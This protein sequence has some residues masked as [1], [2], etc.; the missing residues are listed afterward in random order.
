MDITKKIVLRSLP[1]FLVAVLCAGFISCGDDDEE[2]VPPYY[3]VDPQESSPSSASQNQMLW[4]KWEGKGTNSEGKSCNM[5]LT[6]K[7]DATGHILVSTSGVIMLKKFNSY[8]Y[9]GSILTL[10]LETGDELILY[11]NSL[12]NTSMSVDFSDERGKLEA[13]YSLTKIE[14][15]SDEGGSGGSGEADIEEAPTLVIRHSDATGKYTTSTENYYKKLS[16]TGKYTLCR[17]SDGRGEIGIGSANNLST[18]GGYRVSS[19][20]Y[21]YRDISI[22]SSTYYFF[23]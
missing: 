19:F 13:T 8:T 3:S 21:V 15:Y 14:D 4:G 16:T 5:T 12:S 6:L 9:S 7:S 11:I 23:N 18:W 2:V 22:T 10:N 20:A 1:V 17:H